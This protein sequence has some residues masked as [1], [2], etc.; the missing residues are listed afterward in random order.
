M[1]APLNIAAPLH[2]RAS[3]S[4][5]KRAQEDQLGGILRA[6]FPVPARE[7]GRRL[8]GNGLADMNITRLLHIIHKQ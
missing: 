4:A 3:I 6:T 5:I 8:N 1:S 7:T 2:V